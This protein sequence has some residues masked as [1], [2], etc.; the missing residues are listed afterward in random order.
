[1]PSLESAIHY[2]GTCLFEGTNISVGRGTD[3]PFQQLGAQCLD[4]RMVPELRFQLDS[5]PD[6]ADRVEELLAQLRSTGSAGTPGTPG[7]ASG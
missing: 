3:R 7:R 1:M 2:P 5:L 4:L 6:D